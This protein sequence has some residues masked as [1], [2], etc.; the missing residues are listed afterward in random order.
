ML[1]NFRLN[2]GLDIPVKGAAELK[3][4]K[5]IVSDVVSVKPVNFK[6]LTPKLLVKEGNEVKA[7]S[8]LFVDK[9]RPEIGFASPVSGT[10]ESIVR[11]E[12][13]KLLEVRIKAAETTDYIKFDI[14][15]LGK[16]TAQEIKKVLLESGLWAAIKQ[17]PYENGSWLISRIC[18]DSVRSLFDGSP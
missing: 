6:N 15:E 1:K 3:I 14:P 18:H 8:I 12:K 4:E 17:R 11:G 5:S 2:K 9:Y 7:G 13:R 16:A 10:V